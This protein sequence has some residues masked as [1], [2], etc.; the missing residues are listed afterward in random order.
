MANV[1]F[2]VEGETE[3]QFYKN[4]LQDYYR[5]EDGYFQHYFSV[6]MM[7]QK[8]NTYNRI[9]KGGR[10]TYDTC[11]KN[12]LRFLTQTSHCA[13]VLLIFDYYGLDESFKTHLSSEQKTLE[14]KVKHIQERLETDVNN[15]RFK[16]R[17][18]V[19]EFEAFLF[20]DVEVIANHFSSYGDKIEELRSIVDSFSENPEYINNSPITAPSKR[21]DAMY[22]G[23]EKSKTTDGIII[24][25]NIGVAK[26]REQ[27]SHFDAICKLIDDLE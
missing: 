17:L 3:E 9:S 15:P 13:L 14:G 16:F 19:H 10:I 26:I 1:F 21:L 23:F 6:V 4:T 2:I 11:L 12:V 5:L 24:A 8:K 7:P 27:C 18:Q 20:S 25:K 22:P